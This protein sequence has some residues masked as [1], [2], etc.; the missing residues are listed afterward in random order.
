MIQNYQLQ[1]FTIHNY[2]PLSKLIIYP[3]ASWICCFLC[4]HWL[5]KNL[6]VTKSVWFQAK[7]RQWEIWKTQLFWFFPLSKIDECTCRVLWPLN[8]FYK[9]IGFDPV[10]YGQPPTSKNLELASDPF[11]SIALSNLLQPL[12]PLEVTVLRLEDPLG[13][14]KD[15]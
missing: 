10:L 13:H 8:D 5:T 1:L 11:W 14:Q 7:S 6:F 3:L 4:L 2:L 9:K 15:L 12:Q